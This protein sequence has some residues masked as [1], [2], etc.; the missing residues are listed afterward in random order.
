MVVGVDE[1]REDRS[2]FQVDGSGRRLTGVDCLDPNNPVPGNRYRHPLA[3][4]RSV[5]DPGIPEKLVGQI[6][7]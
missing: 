4:P 2:A 6:R 3:D 5:D 1:T 7:P